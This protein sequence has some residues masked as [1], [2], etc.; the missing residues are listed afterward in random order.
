MQMPTV[1]TN[2]L[3]QTDNIKSFVTRM[4]KLYKFDRPI[5]EDRAQR[6][7]ERFQITIPVV[8]TPLNDDFQPKPYEW[9]GVTR[10]ISDLGAGFVLNSPIDCDYLLLEFEPC[11]NSQLCLI[12]KFVFCREEGFYFRV[13]CEFLY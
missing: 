13:G 1:P 3:S 11:D 7:T 9:E 5:G 10:D 12:A 4:K 6:R 8:V 2:I